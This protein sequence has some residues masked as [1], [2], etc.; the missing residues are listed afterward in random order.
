MQKE[1]LDLNK[2][3]QL[4]S[5]ANIIRQLRTIQT[6]ILQRLARAILP[7]VTQLEHRIRV[8]ARTNEV[9]MYLPIHPIEQQ[10]LIAR[11]AKN[12]FGQRG[13]VAKH[14]AEYLRQKFR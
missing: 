9:I 8:V 10:M 2:L 3:E 7:L 14:I 13:A 6:P 5:E 11:A 12:N 1:F 4:H